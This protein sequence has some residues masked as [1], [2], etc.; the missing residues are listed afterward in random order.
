MTG[1]GGIQMKKFR[2][3]KIAPKLISCFLLIAFL[4]AAVGIIGILQIKKINLSSASMY[5]DNIIHIRKVG[6]LKENFLQIHSDLLSLLITKD[7][8]KKQQIEEE[9]NKLTE[10]DMDIS[11][12]FEDTNAT[13]Q[14]KELL[15]KFNK[16]HEDYMMARKKFIELINSNKYDEAQM[17]FD[18][19]VEAR[20]KTFNDINELININLKEAEEANKTNGLIY[21]ATFNMMVSIVI[22][23]FI[24]AIVFGI[25]ISTSL[26]KGINKVL[27]FANALGDGDL[28]KRIDIYAKDEIGKLSVSLNKAVENTRNLISAIISGSVDMSSSSEEVSA[29]IEEISAK[30][31]DI[32]Q[33][34]KEISAGTENL[35]TISEKVNASIQEIT[36]NT[37]ELS[38]KAEDGNRASEEVQARAAEIKDKGLKAINI[39]QKIYKE[40]QVN[41]IKAIEDG[42]VVEKIKVMADSIA[43]IASKTNL[44]ALNA[45]IE[46]ARAG[47]AGKGFAVV[48]DEIRKLAEQSAINVSNIQ[49]V[50][51]QVNEAFHNLSNNTQDILAFIDNNV[52]PDYELFL[53]TAE[54]YEK[55]AAFIKTM[56]G[57]IAFGTAQILNSI[58]Q[59]SSAIDN[60]SSTARLSASSSQG[61]LSSV[62]ET[63]IAVR[64]VSESVQRQAELAEELNNLVNKFKI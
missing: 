53:E 41:I 22:F 60:V 31:N 26:S 46:S 58:E 62:D 64:E 16:N 15:I 52:N 34:T 57:G 36:S 27:I 56:S 33:A 14:E 32:N 37:T 2:N 7:P 55:D 49:N 3:L 42:K 44:L 18:M 13:D 39:S 21:K 24:I 10:E 1:Y 28:T 59:T 12:K 61:I 5:E 43:E 8:S 45:A 20:Q 25:L 63:S 17:S 35:G 9:I 29:A 30:M 51:A 4:I 23:G 40:K 50:I 6:A 54:K 48:A 11:K 19:V 47:D 38:S